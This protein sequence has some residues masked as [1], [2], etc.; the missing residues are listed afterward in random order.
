MVVGSIYDK[1]TNHKHIGE[2]G[3][4]LPA[5]TCRAPA[6]PS[7][8]G[9]GPGRRRAPPPGPA[10]PAGGRAAGASGRP[11][12]RPRPAT[13]FTFRY[14]R[15]SD[16]HYLVSEVSY[17]FFLLGRRLDPKYNQVRRRGHRCLKPTSHL[18]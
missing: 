5:S 17:L 15:V 11:P 9:C 14:A 7:L 16:C 1:E 8:L 2:I 18:H 10:G 3:M 13:H 4:T 12:P 6:L